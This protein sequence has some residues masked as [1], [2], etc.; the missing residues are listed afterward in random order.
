M[1]KFI[2]FPYRVSSEWCLPKIIIIG[3]YFHWVVQS[4]KGVWGLTFLLEHTVVLK[5]LAFVDIKDI[6]NVF[7][8]LQYVPC[9]VIHV[10]KFLDKSSSATRTAVIPAMASKRTDSAQVTA[11]RL[12]FNFTLCQMGRTY[13]IGNPFGRRKNF[14]S[15]IMENMP[16]CKWCKGLES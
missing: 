14:F 13:M 6:F 4:K 10:A 3:L 15:T 9:T 11:L 16:I 7:I 2:S 12:L 8:C 1:G 5:W